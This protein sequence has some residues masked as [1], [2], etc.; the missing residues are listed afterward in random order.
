[1][2][3]D[4]RINS[5]EE[6]CFIKY[7]IY[8]SDFTRVHYSCKNFQY[9]FLIKLTPV[10]R[11]CMLMLG[12]KKFTFQFNQSSSAKLVQNTVTFCWFAVYNMLLVLLGKQRILTRFEK[13]IFESCQVWMLKKH[14]S[15]L[16]F[17]RLETYFSAL[18]LWNL[19]IA[20]ALWK[21]GTSTYC[22][23]WIKFT[24]CGRPK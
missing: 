1:M 10:W 22:T 9:I 14:T 8:K 19:G 24:Q 2:T 5:G 21:S 11:I 4:T 18:L 20:G 13:G 23:Q 15:L 3:R 6:Y 17:Y 16:Q 7:C 12:C